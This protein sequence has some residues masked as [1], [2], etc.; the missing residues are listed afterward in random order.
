MNILFLTLKFSNFI[1]YF[2]N[3]CWSCIYYINQMYLSNL[4]YVMKSIKSCVH[5]TSHEY[6]VRVR[7]FSPCVSLIKLNAWENKWITNVKVL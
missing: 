2:T 3:I 6:V 7:F 1:N 5:F 4:K